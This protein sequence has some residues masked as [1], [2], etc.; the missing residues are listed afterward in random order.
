M[1]SPSFLSPRRFVTSS[2]CPAIELSFVASRP[3]FALHVFRVTQTIWIRPNFISSAPN[4]A[5][6]P[7]QNFVSS[8]SRRVRTSYR[9]CR[10]TFKLV[11]S[12]P[13]HTSKFVS[14]LHHFI[15]HSRCCLFFLVTSR[16]NFHILFHASHTKPSPS[17]S[18]HILTR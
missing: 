15:S 8:S 17:Y 4:R 2:S 9:L 6:P 3:N 13:R 5:L 7:L 16:P 1:P 14:I 18:L 11:S 10:V 12:S